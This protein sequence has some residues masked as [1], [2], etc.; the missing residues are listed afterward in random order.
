MVLTEPCGTS[1]GFVYMEL[2]DCSDIFPFFIICCSI[3]CVCMNVCCVSITLFLT[4]SEP[5]SRFFNDFVVI[6]AIDSI[7]FYLFAYLLVLG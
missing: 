7:N 2:S 5:A 4:H 3:L 1:N 6:M